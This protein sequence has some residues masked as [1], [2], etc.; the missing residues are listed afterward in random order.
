MSTADTLGI[1]LAGGAG[2]RVGGADKGLLPVHGKPV[3]ERIAAVLRPQCGELVIVAN[4][5]TADYAR[6]GRVI[7]DETPGHAGP[8]AGIAAALALA[9][10]P[11]AE[12]HAGYRW[13]LTVPVDCPDFPSDLFQRLHAVLAGDPRLPCA[14]AR[15][16]HK[17]QPLFALY[18]MEHGKQ[19]LHSARAAVQLHAS[20]L[21]WHLELHAQ[22]VDFRDQTDAFRNL[23]ALKDFREYET[24]HE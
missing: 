19:L 7:A 4:R 6:V 18:S 12:A 10:E 22:P 3:V 5:N 13:M 24:S 17:V 9:V 20:V 15:D 16:E 1:V 11:P 2:A 14:Y 23:N 8:L 21:R